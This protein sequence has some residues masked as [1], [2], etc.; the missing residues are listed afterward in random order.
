[1]RRVKVLRIIARLNIGGP[2]IHTI[3]LTAG[4]NNERFEPLLVTGVEGRREG[5]MLDLAAAKGV[6]PIVIPELRRN[7][8]PRMPLSPWSSSTA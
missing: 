1:M 5:N 2:A 4:L 7:P 3:L 6:E 8:A